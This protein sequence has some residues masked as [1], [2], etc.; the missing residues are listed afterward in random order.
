MARLIK[1]Y[2]SEMAGI[3]LVEENKMKWQ[4]ISL[5]KD[6]VQRRIVDL[7]DNIKE[8]AITELQNLQFGLLSI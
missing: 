8:Q 7:S 4:Q 2:A 5:S 6:T 3:V 1:P